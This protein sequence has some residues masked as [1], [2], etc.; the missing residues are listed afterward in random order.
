MHALS[1]LSGLALVVLLVGF[2]LA[3]RPVHVFIAGDST[4]AE[5]RADRRPETG[6]GEHL[7]AF[8][9]TDDVRV[10]NL[11]RNG[12]STRTFIEEG[13]WASLLEEVRPG[14]VVLIQFGHNDQSESKLDRYTPPVAFQAN[15][16]RFVADVRQLDATPVL[17]TPIVRRRFDADGQF[18]DVH[19]AYPDLTRAVAR[20]TGAALVDMHRASEAVL[21]ERG[22]EGSTSLFLRLAPGE[23]ANYPDGLDDN[24]HLSP[25]GASVM[26]RLAAEGLRDTGLPLAERLLLAEPVAWDAIVG[27]PAGLRPEAEGAARFETVGAALA[28]IP[29]ERD[30]PYRVLIGDGRYREK[31]IVAAP[32]I[33]LVG[34]SRDGTVL[35]FDDA[36]GMLGPDGQAVGTSGSATIR[37][38]AP[39]FRA[40]TLTIENA[41]DYPA[42]EAKPDGDPTKLGSPQG[43]ALTLDAGSDRTVLS[44]VAL[45]G[46]Q[47]TFFPDA[48]RT[49]VWRSRIAGHVD[50]IFGGGQVVFAEC[51]ILSRDRAD[52][53]PTGYVTAPSTRASLPFGFLFVDTR[54]EKEPGV[55]AGSVRLGRP[56]HPGND[57]TANGSAVFVRSFMDDHVG[58]DGYAPISGRTADGERV[59]YDLEPTS[60]FFETETTGPGAHIGPRRPQLLLEAA[61]AYTPGRVLSG[62]RPTRSLYGPPTRA[63]VED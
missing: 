10:V 54:F 24:T 29:A 38:S 25:L 20:E 3:P 33:H 7:Q 15:L 40:E 45:I 17:L 13:R 41:F 16:R 57:P 19:G 30:G 37:V 22:E 9:D 62:W 35:T 31:L 11:A 42:N 21:R 58:E 39:G 12:R 1:R 43:V 14:D 56:W 49:Y 44:E 36:S 46:Y 23:H 2:V 60:R 51:V 8:F 18:Y 52:K 61:A 63:G 32:D 5:K 34:E 6:W 26:A 53:N 27:D 50:F 55:L 47:D 4:A 48:G 28:A 59:W